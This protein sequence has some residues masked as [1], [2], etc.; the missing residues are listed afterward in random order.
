[1]GKLASLTDKNIFSSPLTKIQKRDSKFRDIMLCLSSF[2]FKMS[3]SSIQA[4]SP[5]KTCI[6]LPD[7]DTNDVPLLNKRMSNFKFSSMK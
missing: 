5:L 7:A 1:M 2:T 4:K 3:S 6:I